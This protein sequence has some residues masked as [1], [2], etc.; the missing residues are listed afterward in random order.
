LGRSGAW[1]AA[2]PAFGPRGAWERGQPMRK[3]W[4]RTALLYVA[5]LI[6]VAAV[7][8]WLG[9]WLGLRRVEAGKQL[10]Q[11]QMQSFLKD[12][13]VG[14]EVGKMFP[15]IPVW[16]ADGTQ[17]FGIHELL[18]HGGVL[19]FI[20]SGCNSCLAALQALHDAQTAAGAEARA[21]L[22]VLDGDPDSLASGL[23]ENGL[24]M[25]FYH[26]AERS[27]A[28]QYHVGIFP[29]SFV[30]ADDGTVAEMIAGTYTREEFEEALLP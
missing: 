3:G 17:A 4:L 14:I 26:D 21:A 23:R 1:P 27:F 30:L 5:V 16:S 15:D 11:A 6:V 10:E 22:V 18:P 19:V 25:P 28:T 29:T 12:N 20:A 9:T 13:I 8:V 2:M 7:G 24:V